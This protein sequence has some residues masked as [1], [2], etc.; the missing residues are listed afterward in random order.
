[1][2]KSY[3]TFRRWLGGVLL[4]HAVLMLILGQTILFQP[5]QK[6][7]PAFIYYWLGCFAFTGLAAMMAILDFIVVRRRARLQQQEFLANTL[8]E[9][10]EKKPEEKRPPPGTVSRDGIE[11]N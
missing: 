1:M 7:K 3:D 6:S 11:N 2:A 10:A 5:L 4:G 8:R 9:I